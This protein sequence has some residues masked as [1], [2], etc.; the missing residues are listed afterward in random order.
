MAAANLL[1]HRR[2][3]NG[4]YHSARPARHPALQRCRIQ[5]GHGDMSCSQSRTPRIPEA[6]LVPVRRTG[7]PVGQKLARIRRYTIPVANPPPLDLPADVVDQCVQLAPLAGDVEVKGLLDHPRALLADRHRDERLARPAPG[8][9][10]P[11]GPEGPISKWASGGS[12]GE[13]MM[14]LLRSAAMPLRSSPGRC[15]RCQLLSG[16]YHPVRRL[17]YRCGA[18]AATVSLPQAGPPILSVSPGPASKEKPWLPGRTPSRILARRGA[19]CRQL[20]ALRGSGGRSWLYAITSLTWPTRSTA[21]VRLLSRF[22]EPIRLSRSIMPGTRWDRSRIRGGDQGIP[23]S[24]ACMLAGA[25]VLLA[26]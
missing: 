2:N 10:F 22:G 12:Y 18:P 5:P 19:P 7:C 11:V 20:A 21:V 8:S 23:G 15:P 13:L 17:E 4:H 1:R 9:R 14:G 24:Y 16:S 3:D 26:G 25:S 6:R